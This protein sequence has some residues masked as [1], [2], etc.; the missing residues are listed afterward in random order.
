MAS[1]ASP[2]DISAAQD[3]ALRVP[4]APSRSRLQR[5][6]AMF[7]LSTGQQAM[8]DAM[9][10]SSSP[11][12]IPDVLGKRP[13]LGSESPDGGDTEPEGAIRD[14]GIASVVP[15]FSN[16]AADVHRFAARKKLRPEQR[17]DLDSFLQVRVPLV[18]PECYGNF[19]RVLSLADRAD[20][21][22][23]CKR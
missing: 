21:M 1:D 4:L 19:G 14:V 8:L 13:R 6:G 11:V 7:I 3:G 22:Y 16:V 23:V 5:E 12:P 20:C 9:D 18:Y 2:V 15:S 10:R 17:D